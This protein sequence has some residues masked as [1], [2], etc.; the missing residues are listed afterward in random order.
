M[1]YFLD[2]HFRGFELGKRLLRGPEGLW[3]A[4]RPP[5]AR[6]CQR[7]D[8]KGMEGTADAR[9][10]IQQLNAVDFLKRQ[11][12]LAWVARY[13]GNLPIIFHLL[14]EAEGERRFGVT[15]APWS[16]AAAM[17]R[18]EQGRLR[19]HKGGDPR[20]IFSTSRHPRGRDGMGKGGREGEGGGAGWKSVAEGR[21]ESSPDLVVSFLP[22]RFG[23]AGARSCV[24]RVS[25]PVLRVG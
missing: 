24:G 14:R 9:A 6:F 25:L 13:S 8:F 5:S 11:A 22:Y 2:G 12:G 19:G 18:G 16:W 10:A 17:A 7:L 20:R 4:Q 23:D 21:P 3:G 15:R 1:F